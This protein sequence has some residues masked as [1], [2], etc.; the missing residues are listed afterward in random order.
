MAAD[1]AHFSME[2]PDFSQLQ[3]VADDIENTQVC[4]LST[5]ILGQLAVL[6]YTSAA[7]YENEPNSHLFQPEVGIA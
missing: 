3:A 7:P 5:I 1:C 4:M 6:A 2:E